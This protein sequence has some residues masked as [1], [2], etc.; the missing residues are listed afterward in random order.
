[1]PCAA[2]GGGV[3]VGVRHVNARRDFKQAVGTQC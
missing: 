3:A 1:M 2:V